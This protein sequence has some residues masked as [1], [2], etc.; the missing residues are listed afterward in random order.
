MISLRISDPARNGAQTRQLLSHTSALYGEIALRCRQHDLL[1]RGFDPWQTEGWRSCE[2]KPLVREDERSYVLDRSESGL[3]KCN[4]RG[5]TGFSLLRVTPA[6]QRSACSPQLLKERRWPCGLRRCI[7]A[8]VARHGC[9]T[10]R[11]TGQPMRPIEHRRSAPQL[12]R[13]LRGRLSFYIGRWHVCHENKLTA[14][15]SHHVSTLHAQKHYSRQGSAIK[16]R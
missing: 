13:Q 1:R 11:R 16:F 14:L 7:L 2:C 6:G 10:S 9:G 15:R 8:P 3:G 12:N 4:A 5:V